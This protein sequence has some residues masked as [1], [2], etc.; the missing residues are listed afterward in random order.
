MAEEKEGILKWLS[1]PFVWVAQNIVSFGSW[2]TSP[3]RNAIWGENN[4]QARNSEIIATT[5]AKTREELEALRG[6]A[7]KAKGGILHTPATAVA[8]REAP[9]SAWIA[10]YNSQAAARGGIPTNKGT[11]VQNSVVSDAQNMREKTNAIGAKVQDNI[12]LAD[13]LLGKAEEL[14]NQ[15]LNSPGVIVAG[16]VS[17][18]F[19]RL[20]GSSAGA[21][22]EVGE[23][24]N[25]GVNTKEP[26]KAASHNAAGVASE[27]SAR[28]AFEERGMRI[29]A[30]ELGSEIVRQGAK[31][32]R[33]GAHEG[34]RRLKKQDTWIGALRGMIGLNSS[35]VSRP[36]GTPA[37][38]GKGNQRASRGSK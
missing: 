11:G 26:S 15:Q 7:S 20:F 31:G 12:P 2:V 10:D 8:R 9:D 27:S 29:E 25:R 35:D 37:V 21:V 4:A 14:H 24:T 32:Y 19:S 3:I 18:V 38:E 1:K 16:A 30:A 36:G 5:A 22:K 17:S 13:S 34:N 6:E 28:S 23:S 33:D